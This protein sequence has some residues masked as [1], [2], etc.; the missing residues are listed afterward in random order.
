MQGIFKRLFTIL[1]DYLK[2]EEPHKVTQFENAFEEVERFPGVNRY[3]DFDPKNTSFLSADDF[4]RLM[5]VVR[6]II[7]SLNLENEEIMTSFNTFLDWYHL[8]RSPDVTEK[9][10]KKVDALAEK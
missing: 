7:A 10:L 8:V 3:V 4:R 1:A 2:E 5:R 6:P 9:Q